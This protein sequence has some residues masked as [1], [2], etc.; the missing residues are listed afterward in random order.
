MKMSCRVLGESEQQTNAL[1]AMEKLNKA[2]EMLEKEGKDLRKKAFNIDDVDKLMDE[3]NELKLKLNMKQI[4]EALATPL[5]AAPDYDQDE[6][7]AQSK[8]LERAVLEKQLR[9]YSSCSSCSCCSSARM[10]LPVYYQLVLLPR[11]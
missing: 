8:E 6:L 7:E 10:F 4:D 2:L 3:I 11:K 1:A 5:F 9:T